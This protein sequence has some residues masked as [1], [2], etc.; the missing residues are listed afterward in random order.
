M[1][2]AR[3]RSIQTTKSDRG[4][5][6]LF[7]VQIPGRWRLGAGACPAKCAGGTA[8]HLGEEVSRHGGAPRERLTV[9]AAPGRIAAWCAGGAGD[10]R[11]KTQA[12]SAPSNSEANPPTYYWSGRQDL[13]LRPPGPERQLGS[14]DSLALPGIAS[15]PLDIAAHPDPAHPL[16]GGPDKPCEAGFVPPVSPRSRGNFVL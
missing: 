12:E 7:F 15:H 8:D 1:R 10:G 16:N 11:S 5:S 9:T 6:R 14:C 2:L 3:G 13:N 4:L